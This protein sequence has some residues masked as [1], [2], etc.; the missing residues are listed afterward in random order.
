MLEV[1]PFTY[2]FVMSKIILLLVVSRRQIL[3]RAQ[4]EIKSRLGTLNALTIGTFNHSA[5][6]MRLLRQAVTITLQYRI[7]MQQILFRFGFQPTYTILYYRK[8]VVQNLFFPSIYYLLPTHLF[9]L[10][11]YY[12]L[13]SNFPSYNISPH[14]GRSLSSFDSSLTQG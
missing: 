4:L 7:N 13:Q 1:L 14:C 5:T 11:V 12:V 9:G 8:N 6:N 2:F 10:H 3:H